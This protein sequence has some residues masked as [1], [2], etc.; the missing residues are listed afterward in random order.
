MKGWIG[1]AVA[2]V[3][4]AL[5]CGGAV[6]WASRGAGA[7]L[8]KQLADSKQLVIDNAAADAKRLSDLSTR[9]GDSQSTVQSITGLL[10]ASR[11]QDLRDQA[12]ARAAT[13]AASA[14]SDQLDAIIRLGESGSGDFDA[15]IGRLTDFNS[16]AA[17]ELGI[18]GQGGGG[19]AVQGAGGR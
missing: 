16:R 6:L 19:Q 18:S 13:A 17:S 5:L 10:A 11:A 3:L 12:A 14:A 2:F 4:G 8:R 7:D 9:L 1:Y 15:A